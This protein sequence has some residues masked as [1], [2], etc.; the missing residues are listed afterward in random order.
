MGLGRAGARAC[1]LT[2]VFT[3][4]LDSPEKMAAAARANRDRPILKLKLGR[5]GD[6]ERVAAVREAIGA[7]IA[8][9][10]D[11]NQGLTVDHAIRL[12]RQLEQF[13]LAWFEEP[14]PAERPTEMAL[15]ARGTSIPSPKRLPRSTDRSS[16]S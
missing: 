12:G 8:L 16:R 3:I 2:T 6:P 15:V 10:S 13:G 4:S 1:T 5:P 14:V 11:A 9:M 7:D